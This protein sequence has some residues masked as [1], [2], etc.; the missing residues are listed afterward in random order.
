MSG[1]EPAFEGIWQLQSIDSKTVAAS[2]KPM[3]FFEII[4]TAIRGHDGCNRFFGSLD[5]PGAIKMTRRACSSDTLRLPLDMSDLDAHLRSGRRQ[6]DVLTVPASSN[7]PAS[8]Y[9]LKV[10]AKPGTQPSSPSTDQSR[11]PDPHKRA[12]FEAVQ[13]R[14]RAKIN[15]EPSPSGS[16]KGHVPGKSVAE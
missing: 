14:N 5:R 6:G 11:L 16:H 8:T 1:A 7:Y 15:S 2:G 12:D 10:D 13:E 3:P 9:A 4:G